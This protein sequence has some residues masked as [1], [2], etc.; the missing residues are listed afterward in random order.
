MSFLK[1]RDF[2]EDAKG[3]S[4]LV[5]VVLGFFTL[6]SGTLCRNNQ[7]QSVAEHR[8]KCRRP[9]IRIGRIRLQMYQVIAESNEQHPLGQKGLILHSSVLYAFDPFCTL[10]ALHIII[11]TD[12]CGLYQ[13]FVA[14][15]ATKV[16]PP[17]NLGP[18]VLLKARMAEQG[19]WE[20]NLG[21]RG[22]LHAVFGNMLI[23][24]ATNGTIWSFF[25]QTANLD[26]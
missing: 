7:C 8:H 1:T 17:L 24:K 12:I 5:S 21:K 25:C 11:Y 26:T 6:A 4:S 9:K 22:I 16:N 10:N 3:F 15:F 20:E 14:T 19:L 23:L 2:Q 13:L 18:L